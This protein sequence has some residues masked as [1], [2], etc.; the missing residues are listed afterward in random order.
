MVSKRCFFE[1]DISW[2]YDLQDLYLG[3]PYT[4]YTIIKKMPIPNN[5]QFSVAI[6]HFNQHP[7]IPVMF[8]VKDVN[9]LPKLFEIISTLQNTVYCLFFVKEWSLPMPSTFNPAKHFM[10]DDISILDIKR[11]ANQYINIIGSVRCYSRDWIL[12]SPVMNRVFKDADGIFDGIS[13][14]MPNA[15]QQPIEILLEI[16]NKGYM[17]LVNI[18]SLPKKDL[19]K[20]SNKYN[21]IGM[22]DNIDL[23]TSY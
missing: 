21:Y 15:G 16:A 18:D 2:D 9:A 4:F 10:L 1:I 20:L 8:D 17:P 23:A 13:L 3:H 7:E 14:Y 12:K 6:E 19:A 22:T 11:F 5:I